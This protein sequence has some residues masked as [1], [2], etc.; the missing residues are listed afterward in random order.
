VEEGIGLADMNK[1]WMR[2]GLV[3]AVGVSLGAQST[4]KSPQNS[5]GA[6][7]TETVEADPIRCWWRT[8][9]GAVRVGESFTVVLTCAVVENDTTIVVPDQSRLEPTP[10]QLPP[11]Q[12][13]RGPAS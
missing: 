9:A 3:L 13:T 11:F 12:A 1:G 10:M 2:L 7:P 6:P 4:P 5:A 8:S